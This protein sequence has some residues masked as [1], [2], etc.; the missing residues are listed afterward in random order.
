MYLSRPSTY[1]CA[2]S[3]TQTHCSR[4]RQLRDTSRGRTGTWE[5]SRPCSRERCREGGRACREYHMVRIKTLMQPSATTK[6]FPSTACHSSPVHH[7]SLLITHNSYVYQSIRSVQWSQHR[8]G[9]EE[10]RRTLC[11]TLRTT[12]DKE[13]RESMKP[14]T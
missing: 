9:H 13:D 14:L 2:Q 12:T 1:Q 3:T 6:S 10:R 8:P 5:S 11:T 7:S 4:G